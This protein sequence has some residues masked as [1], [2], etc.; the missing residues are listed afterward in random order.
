MERTKSRARV[1]RTAVSLAAVVPAGFYAKLYRGPGAHWVND[2]FA[3]VF[4]EV[5]WCLVLSL[6]LPA[7]SGRRIA[8]A[9]L[10]AT[11]ALEFMQLWHPPLLEYLRSFTLG[12]ALLG[13]WF[14]WWDF[15]YYFLGS[16]VG[17]LWLKL[18]DSR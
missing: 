9:V 15:P 3:A 7:W 18:I 4:Y 12:G 16:G 8:L 10:A 1:V 13:N 17:W 2:S 6:L 5:F 11:C 14:D